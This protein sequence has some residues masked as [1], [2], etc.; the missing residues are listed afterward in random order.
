MREERSQKKELGM[1]ARGREERR[2]RSRRK[3]RGK[4]RSGDSP[5]TESLSSS[6][7]VNVAWFCTS[8]ASYEEDGPP[9]P[10]RDVLMD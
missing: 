5:V 4:G 9:P 10:S 8:C 1:E 3:R 6:G 2:E 7:L